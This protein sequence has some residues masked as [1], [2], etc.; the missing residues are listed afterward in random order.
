MVIMY[1]DN[2]GVE[3][4]PK[5]KFIGNKKYINIYRIQAYDSKMCGYFCIGFIYF[6]FKGTS[7][8]VYK[9]LF[10]STGYE[11]MVKY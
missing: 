1:F 8:L 4:M 7:L 3:D 11:K 10:S 2:F 6:M 9:N 5:E